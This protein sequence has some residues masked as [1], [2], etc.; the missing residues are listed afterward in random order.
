M[1]DD[2]EIFKVLQRHHV[3]FVVIGGHA[4]NYHGYGRT[5]ED[6]D[7]VWLRSPTAEQS[8]HA[9]LREIDAAYIGNQIDPATGIEQTLPVSLPFIQSTSL[10]MLVTRHGFLDLFD[11]VPGVPAENPGALLDSAVETGGLKYVSLG[12]LRRLK[13]VSGRPKDVI[14]LQNLPE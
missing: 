6:V 3:P 14:D 12:W 11:Y 2:Q 8:L 1:R 9:A 4:V 5:T 13:E 10:M 7:I